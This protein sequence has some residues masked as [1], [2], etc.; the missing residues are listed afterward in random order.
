MIA[1]VTLNPAFDK[2]VYVDKLE[3]YDANRVKRTEIDAGGKGINASRVLKELGSETK[4]LGFL[5]GKTG[6][7]VEHVLSI[8]G[9]PCDFVHTE[10]ETRTN[11][12]IQDASG[13]P[14]TVLNEPGPHITEKELDELIEKVRKA[15]GESSMV[16]IGGSLPPGVPVD[17][18]HTLVSI[19][20][21]AGAKAILDAD[22]TP[23][24]RGLDS[25]PYMIKPNL[26][27]VKRLVGEQV[28]TADDA[29]NAANELAKY[30]INVII[31][32]MGARGSVA[33]SAEGVFHAMPPQVKVVS[34]I[35]SGDSMIAGVTH[36]LSRSGSLEEA[37]R[38][39][40]AAGA[41]TAMTDG[42]DI[43]SQKQVLEL[44]D[45]VRIERLS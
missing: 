28:K 21:K 32:S 31:V 34:T 12:S 9:I 2:T 23:M 36:I 8:E 4:A 35:G 24:I 38:W 10:T 45:L 6:R 15:A 5:G 11:I 42:T 30:G 22:G 40:T 13:A 7:F 41:A 18:Y 17:I 27:E 14:P 16:I 20:Q 39:G 43:C 29:A 19:I 33:R 44:L 26:D 25:A 3:P 37:L 1:S